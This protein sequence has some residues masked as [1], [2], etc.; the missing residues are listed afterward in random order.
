MNQ[1]HTKVNK[2]SLVQQRLKDNK[3]IV[4]SHLS[5]CESFLRKSQYSDQIELM[6]NPMK[7]EQ[8]GEFFQGQSFD[9]Q[10]NNRRENSCLKG[11]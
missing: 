5:T 8:V 7:I 4:D 9:V 3:L 6:A 1:Q 11:D 10:E 2:I